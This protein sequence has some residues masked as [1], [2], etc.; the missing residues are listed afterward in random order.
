MFGIWCGDILAPPKNIWPSDC[1]VSFDQA[2][3]V[4]VLD[5][6]LPIPSNLGP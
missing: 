1:D 5:P 4:I 6:S 3:C 2:K